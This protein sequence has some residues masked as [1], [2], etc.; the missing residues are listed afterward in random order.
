M[1]YIKKNRRRLLCWLL[2]VVL[3]TATCLP[4]LGRSRVEYENPISQ[5]S[6]ED[7]RVVHA[8][9]AQNLTG[10]GTQDTDGTG[11]G[12]AGG[13]TG[14]RGGN[15][16]GESDKPAS[17]ADTEEKTENIENDTDSKTGPSL[18]DLSNSE[19]GSSPDIQPQGQEGQEEGNQGEEGGEEA[20]LQLGAVFY[21]HKYGRDPRSIVCQPNEVVGKQIMTAQLADEKLVYEI[22]L[23][24]EDA[25]KAR[26]TAVT[27][28]EGNSAGVPVE[29]SGA[30]P[31][32]VRADPG[33]QSYIFLVEAEAEGEPI[34]FTYVI[35]CESGKDLD[36]HLTWN[37]KDGDTAAVVCYAD[38]EAIKSV[39]GKHLTEGAFTFTTHFEGD[40][41]D[42]AQLV[43]AEYRTDSG[44]TGTLNPDGDTIQMA[45]PVGMDREN[46]YLHFTARVTGTDSDGDPVEL[47]I[48]YGITIVYEN[49]LDL[50]LVFTWYDRGITPRDLHCRVNDQV[51]GRVKNNQ[52]S[53]GALAYDIR[54]EGS[55]ADNARIKVV[56]C[57]ADSGG[58]VSLEPSGSMPMNL[59]EGAS[60][61]T[62]T[63]LI[64][65]QVG[66]QKANFTVRMDYSRDVSLQM[67]FTT[68]TGE[69]ILTCENGR[70][71]TAQLVFDDELEDGMLSYSMTLPENITITDVHF[72]QSGTM[73]NQHLEPAGTVQL[74]LDGG[75]TGEN[76]FRVTA[77]DDGGADYHFFIN[78]PYKHRGE[79][80]VKIAT[81]LTDGMEVT[82]GTE[83]NLNVRAWVEDEQGNT[84][85]HILATGTNGSK[86]TVWLDGE[87]IPYF[88]AS[89]AAQEYLL[90]PKDPEVGDTN[91]HI[92]K[93]YAEDAFG[94]YGQL[95]LTLRG[96]RTQN[97]QILGT[98]Q[99]YI[100]MTVLGLGVE[101][102]VSYTVL[103]EEPVS[104]VVPKVVWG[105]DTGDPFGYAEHT[106]G[107]V[108]GTIAGTVEDGFYLR[109]MSPP[110]PVAAQAMS[111]R[112]WGDVGSTDE[113][114]LAAIDNTLGRGSGLATLWRCIYRNNLHLS[115]ASPSSIGEFDFT[116]GSGWLYSIGGGDYY[117]GSSMSN[118]FLKDGDVLTLRY[119][120]AQGWDVGSGTEGYGNTVGY[121]VSAMNGVFDI[122]HQ[123]EEQ[124][125][126]D[127]SIRYVCK[128]CG[129]VEEC[130]HEHTEYRDLGDGTHA[131]FCLDCNTLISPPEAHIWEY[132]DLEDPTYH[133]LQCRLCGAAQQELHQ[134]EELSNTATCTEPGIR[135][136]Q[137]NVCGITQEQE[138][139]AKGH[140]TDN[141]FFFDGQEHYQLCE[142]CGLE[143]PGSRGRHTWVY[144]EMEDDWFCS[145]CQAG[146]G[147]DMDHYLDDSN[148][149]SATCQELWYHCPDCNQDFVRTGTFD[150]YHEYENGSCI[151]CGQPDPDYVSPEEP[152][153]EPS[154]EPPAEFRS[155]RKSRKGRT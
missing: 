131:T 83:V 25:D 45:V 61:E 93:I 64:T 111:G 1:E 97:G 133:T 52:L 109:S 113:E 39:N 145:A 141:Q 79:N 91:T 40:L 129:L 42:T 75:E 54:L 106:F 24:G 101:G 122:H 16:S 121:C 150:A 94:N 118:Y 28:S 6:V 125:G 30:V 144:N 9:E 95:E 18:E 82:N 62:Y 76:S 112:N 110:N 80:L 3:V 104:N 120:L 37:E 146:H 87:E 14:N 107:W 68:L 151:Y 78:I 128:C 149:V 147:W 49:I 105:A 108:G 99:V 15:E 116:N 92:L 117:P 130:G 19:I 142:I 13:Q 153:V 114:I 41:A 67:R 21:W 4:L 154:I 20:E 5:R 17:G 23:T 8:G 143:V 46:Y 139:P 138:V 48:T 127:G 103:S 56:S 85:S 77:V 72:Y 50:Q 60:S 96:K 53:A 100:D 36:L 51:V 7:I 34:T 102:P 69:K 2:V 26:I 11:S 98:A 84:I 32:H 35:R 90:I 89:G 137:C 43:S 119:T 134:W 86:I 152:P 59:P 71:V 55:D 70:S 73:R 33:Y 135:T 22:Q 66:K 10:S 57:R 126:E 140:Q 65:V 12:E 155:L 44:E 132:G 29:T 38:R 74:A 115:T 27:C 148:L 58:T 47:T 123:M 81:N 124:V 136:V 31:V 63:F 88:S